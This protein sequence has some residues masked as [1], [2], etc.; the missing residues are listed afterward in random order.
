MFYCG[1]IYSTI[2]YGIPSPRTAAG[3]V[4]TCAYALVGIPLFL[5]I[6]KVY[7][8]KSPGDNKRLS[9]KNLKEVGVHLSRALRRAWRHGKDHLKKIRNRTS[10]GAVDLEASGT[11]ARLP[12]SLHFDVSQELSKAASV[13]P[14]C[15]SLGI[16]LWSSSSYGSPSVRVFSASGSPAGATAHLSTLSSSHCLQS[17]WATLCLRSRISCSPTLSFYS[18][19]WPCFL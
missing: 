12:P 15:L 17:A 16:C 19:A 1:T 11:Q 13:N 18:S 5:T 7:F 14:V 4:F 2:G 6:L 10:P 9:T 3:R 8:S